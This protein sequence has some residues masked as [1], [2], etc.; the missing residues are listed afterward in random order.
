MKPVPPWQRYMQEGVGVMIWTCPA[1]EALAGREAG[2]RGTL[3][4]ES[5]A[6]G[7]ETPSACARAACTSGVEE[8]ASA[9]ARMETGGGRARWRLGSLGGTLCRAV[10]RALRA[11]R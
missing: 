10:G 2:G 11:A 1:V 7:G 5:P 6:A 4:R 3:P 8:P 9:Q